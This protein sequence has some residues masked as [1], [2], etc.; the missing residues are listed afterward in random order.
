MGVLHPFIGDV[1]VCCLPPLIGN[2]YPF[3]GVVGACCQ[4]PFMSHVGVSC[5]HPSWPLQYLYYLWFQVPIWGLW[6]YPHG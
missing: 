2:L 6:T 3:I 1:G 5:L 4:H